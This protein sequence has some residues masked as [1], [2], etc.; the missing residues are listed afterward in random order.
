MPLEDSTAQVAA[1][2]SANGSI[3]KAVDMAALQSML[4]DLPASDSGYNVPATLIT[5][6][7]G[8]PEDKVGV[9]RLLMLSGVAADRAAEL[10]ENMQDRLPNSAAR[11]PAALLTAHA[12]DSGPTTWPLLKGSIEE[13][14]GFTAVERRKLLKLLDKLPRC[15]EPSEQDC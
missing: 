11:G 4:Q 7:A 8:L 2:A 15:S 6:L 1:E 9:A 10:A 5:E 12:G 13:G 14:C 3:G